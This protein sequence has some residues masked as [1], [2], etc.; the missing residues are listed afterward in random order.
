MFIWMPP[1]EGP[2]SRPAANEEPEDQPG[3]QPSASDFFVL[4]D[5]VASRAIRDFAGM[6][7]RWVPLKTDFWQQ[8]YELHCG[9]EILG[10]MHCNLE[11][12]RGLARTKEGTWSFRVY[13]GDRGAVA[14]ETDKGERT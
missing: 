10:L 7:L 6:P 3:N 4:P 5:S 8:T 13:R 9:E 1:T 11:S 14:I 12:C 2:D